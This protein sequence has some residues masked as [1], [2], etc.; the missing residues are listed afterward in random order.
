MLHLT[1]SL[2]CGKWP[3]FVEGTSIY[4]MEKECVGSANAIS[5]IGFWM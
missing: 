4:F 2:R 5:T 1:P 3:N